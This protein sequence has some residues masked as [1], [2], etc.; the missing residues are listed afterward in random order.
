[1]SIPLENLRT[2]YTELCQTVTTAIQ[3]QSGNAIALDRCKQLC[4][5]FLGEIQHVSA[6]REE[7]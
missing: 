7:R 2:A 6:L 3:T 1:M 5:W 4:L